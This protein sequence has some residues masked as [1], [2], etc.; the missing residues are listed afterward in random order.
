MRKDRRFGKPAH[1]RALVSIGLVCALLF[2]TGPAASEDGAEQIRARIGRAMQDELVVGAVVGVT[3]NGRMVFEEAFGWADREA[4]RPQKVDNIFPI[5]S[6][7][8]P[9]A[10][11]AI[12]ILVDHGYMALD[13]PALKWFPVLANAHLEDGQPVPSPT[14][15]GL[16]SCTSGIFTRQ[17][18]PEKN[19]LIRQWDSTLARQAELIVRQPFAYPPRTDYSYGGTQM[20]VAARIAELVT[21]MEFDEVATWLVFEPLGMPDTFYRRDQ[22]L[23]DR[24][25]IQYLKTERGIVRLRGQPAVGDAIPI[26]NNRFV[27]APGG[28]RSTVRDL[29]RFLEVH[30]GYGK[31]LN[32]RLLSQEMAVEMRT[33][34]TAPFRGDRDEMMH[35]GLGWQLDELDEDHVG[36]VFSHGGAYG[37]LIWGDAKAGLGVAMV[38]NRD[39]YGLQTV[40]PVWDDVIRIARETWK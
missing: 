11:T 4:K 2:V 18:R 9:L 24:Y 33:D 40:R 6:T 17:T 8:K 21:E 13:D 14:L 3:H 28:I 27:L 20:L 16:M 10:M 32:R 34:Q 37:T 38:T 30:L 12:A 22:D 29:C 5:G 23:S 36:A 15:R 31:A 25:S 7:S 35:Y 39:P 26:Y 19:Y 1:G